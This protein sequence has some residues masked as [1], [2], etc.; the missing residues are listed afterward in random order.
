MIEDEG[1]ED[2][3][4]FMVGSILMKPCH[5]GGYQG[6]GILQRTALNLER[7]SEDRVQLW[8]EYGGGILWCERRSI[9]LA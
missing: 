7:N 5:N 2:N 1:N 9:R 6:L 8:H 3:A 4:R